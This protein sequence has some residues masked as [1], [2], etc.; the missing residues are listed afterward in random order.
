MDVLEYVEEVRTCTDR[1]RLRKELRIEDN[2]TC[3][4]Y[5]ENSRQAIFTG[6]FQDWNL[7]SSESNLYRHQSRSVQ[8]HLGNCAGYH[9]E[10]PKNTIDGNIHTSYILLHPFRVQEV[11]DLRLTVIDLVTFL[12]DNKIPFRLPQQPLGKNYNPHIVGK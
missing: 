3:L 5:G 9:S 6:F 11:T 4:L 8:A 1:V 12:I 2:W 7:D 10:N